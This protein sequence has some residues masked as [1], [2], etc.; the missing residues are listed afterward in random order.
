MPNSTTFLRSALSL[1]AMALIS[2]PV[3][4]DEKDDV[5]D[6]EPIQVIGQRSFETSDPNNPTAPGMTVKI[7]G[8]DRT[9]GQTLTHGAGLEIVTSGNRG[10]SEEIRL[11][12]ARGHQVGLLL[13]GQPTFFAPGRSVD[14]STFPTLMLDR[15][16]VTKGSNSADY[17]SGH[18]GGTIN[19]MTYSPTDDGVRFRASTGS[20]GL[21]KAALATHAVRSNGRGIVGGEWEKATG[22]FTYVD[23]NQR[24]RIQRNNDHQKHNL[25]T[26]ATWRPRPTQKLTLNGEFFADKRGEPGTMEFPTPTA[27]SQ[28]KRSTVQL[29]YVNADIGR[30]T[31]AFSLGGAFQFRQ[32]RFRSQANAFG[33]QEEH[34]QQFDRSGQLS[35]SLNSVIREAFHL[36]LQGSLQVETVH[37]NQDFTRHYSRQF[38][39][40]TQGLEYHFRNSI[41][42]TVAQQTQMWS[43]QYTY[44]PRAGIA[45]LWV[46]QLRF[47]ANVG[48]FFR[49][50]SIDELYHQSA[51][52]SGNRELKPE[53]G[54]SMDAQ[55][56]LRPT[57]WSIDHVSIGLFRTHFD[58]LIFFAPIDAFRF[59]SQNHPGGQVSGL[60]LSSRINTQNIGLDIHYR[61]QES[62]SRSRRTVLPFRPTHHFTSTLTLRHNAW[63]SGLN[64]RQV[65]NRKVDVFGH[66]SLAAYGE[67]GASI[68][69]DLEAFLISLQFNNLLNGLNHRDIPG[70]SRPGRNFH[71]TI[72]SNS[73]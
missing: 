17:G 20:F 6:E 71:F 7:D 72:G 68:E 49:V 52:V 62:E 44:M 37:L 12:G 64:W 55:L 13:D 19:L 39:N 33:G 2:N 31:S 30:G 63:T 41:T 59:Q 25:F 29:R 24:H 34:F 35:T 5:S 28:R 14:L 1:L 4:A 50:P 32:Y 51:A 45:W 27:K 8:S 21:V 23:D 26:S 60:E 36:R 61:L 57:F 11:R 53:E 38:M 46:P 3:Q 67:L 42:L 10:R 58:S 22:D 66:R 56:E 9:L 47:S 54:Y 15:V 65:S 70:I 43:N 18:M 16:S 69:M 48:R 73:W 40:I